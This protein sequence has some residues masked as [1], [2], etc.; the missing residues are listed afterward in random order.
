MLQNYSKAE[1]LVLLYAVLSKKQSGITFMAIMFPKQLFSGMHDWNKNRNCRV[2]LKVY[3]A[4][5]LTHRELIHCVSSIIL[6]QSYFACICFV[7]IWKK[8]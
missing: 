3:F 8:T 4:I 6:L 1:S 7:D 5:Q 2:G